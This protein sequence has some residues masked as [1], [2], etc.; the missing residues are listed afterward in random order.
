[1]TN[2][3][4]D[5][6][7]LYCCCCNWKP[8]NSCCLRPHYYIGCRSELL[9]RRALNSWNIGASL[10]FFV[11]ICFCSKEMIS[12][13]WYGSAS[14]LFD[15]YEV[16]WLFPDVTPSYQTHPP[17]RP[18]SPVA[19]VWELAHIHFN[20]NVIHSM[21]MCKILGIGLPNISLF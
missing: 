17:H 16:G 8:V 18:S 19:Y 10:Q 12:S 15:L 3:T 9:G 5:I 1:M 11:R 2:M 14:N 6:F 20:W 4:W 21:I 7:P 13:G